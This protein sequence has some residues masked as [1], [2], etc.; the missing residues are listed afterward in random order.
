MAGL[1][2]WCGRN[3]LLVKAYISWLNFSDNAEEMLELCDAVNSRIIDGWVQ[4]NQIG[5]VEYNQE[6][7]YDRLDDIR[8]IIDNSIKKALEVCGISRNAFFGIA[9]S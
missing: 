9:A 4:P 8:G 3:K 5:I 2:Y 6:F 1:A 7:T